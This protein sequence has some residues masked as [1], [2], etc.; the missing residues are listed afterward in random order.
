MDDKRPEDDIEYTINAE[1][2][3]FG[4]GTIPITVKDDDSECGIN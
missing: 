1:A 3:T 2:G 4:S